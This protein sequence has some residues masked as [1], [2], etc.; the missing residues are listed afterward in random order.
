M[1]RIRGTHSGG[2]QAAGSVISPIPITSAAEETYLLDFFQ[3][4]SNSNT[5]GTI[6]IGTSGLSLVGG[7]THSVS[8]N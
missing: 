5:N 4:A 6:T 1:P 8:R 7:G 2:A 3:S